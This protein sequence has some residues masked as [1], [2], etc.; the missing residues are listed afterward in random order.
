[1]TKKHQDV[2]VKTKQKKRMGL[3][4]RL[5]IQD[6]QKVELGKVRILKQT[7]PNIR[8]EVRPNPNISVELLRAKAKNEVYREIRHEAEGPGQ[9]ELTLMSRTPRIVRPIRVLP[10]MR[11]LCPSR[12]T[13]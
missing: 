4:T 12:S 5:K 10:K 7:Q 13:C 2:A 1:M 6:D 8:H 3:V 9:L 11:A